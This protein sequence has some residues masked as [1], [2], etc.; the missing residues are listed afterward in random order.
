M[1]SGQCDELRDLALWLDDEFYDAE[2]SKVR[3][4]A[5]LILELRDNLQCANEAVRDAEHDESMAW[6]RVRKAEAEN[7]K[8]LEA[9]AELLEMAESH[10]PEWLHWPEVHE[11]L[12]QLG[13][14]GGR[15]SESI[16]DLVR[17]VTSYVTALQ[18][19]NTALRQQ[20]ADVTESM[21]RVEERCAKLR[22]LACHL[23]YVKPR[24]VTSVLVEGKLVDLEE[25]MESVGLRW[26]D[27]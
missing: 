19:E 20:L 17:E 11:E 12:R 25:L 4:A 26:E 16:D 10:D 21:G 9:C 14:G 3:Q 23:W 2:A 13:S 22:E 27:A 1:I 5:D 6:D 7:E 8:L 18:A 24:D 15:M